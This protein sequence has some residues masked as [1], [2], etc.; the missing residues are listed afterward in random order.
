MTDDEG[1]DEQDGADEK[2]VLGVDDAGEGDQR[3]GAGAG[4]AAEKAPGDEEPDQ[5]LGLVG[6]EDVVDGDPELGHGQGDEDVGPEA[7]DDDDGV[8]RSSG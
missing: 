6:V 4:D 3:G 5:P 2:E 8:A 1:Q 7:E